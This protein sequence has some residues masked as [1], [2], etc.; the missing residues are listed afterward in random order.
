V[1]VVKVLESIEAPHAIENS[2]RVYVRHASTS[3][4]IEL[5]DIDRIDY[6]LQRRRA[7]E[8][9][10]EELIERAEARSP[11]SPGLVG[12][13]HRRLRVVVTP[14][15]PRGTLFSYDG[16][17]ELA[18]RLDDKAD[19]MMRN[20]RMVH[21]GVMGGRLA[22]PSADHHL[23]VS[24]QGVLFFEEPV[25]YSGTSQDQQTQFIFL[26]DALWP[27]ARGVNIALPFFSGLLTNL[28]IRCELYE[29]HGVAFLHV[30]PS[31][32]V[33]PELLIAQRRSTDHLISVSTYV[34]A[35]DL[36]DQRI[37]ILTDVLRRML[38]AFSYRAGGDFKDT[39]EQSIKASGLA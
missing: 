7:P 15:F 25:E 36:R 26:K 1:A 3:T 22:D 21:E 30:E 32:L 23:E 11:L 17:F 9:W 27:L 39:I 10:R 4:P 2:T 5:A 18:K 29:C 6:L 8:K 31:K 13:P 34:A 24:T 35:D 33:R 14:V 38:W 16:L 37:E 20:F 19:R 12:Q 28:L